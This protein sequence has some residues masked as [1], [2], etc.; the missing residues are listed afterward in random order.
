MLFKCK[1]AKIKAL[2]IKE[3]KM[4]A[5]N[6]RPISLLP[7]ISKVI[8]KLIHDQT[9]DYL[10]RNELL[11]IYQSG[12]RVNHSADKCLPR[13]TDMILN[14]SKNGKHTHITLL[15]LQKAFD[16]SDHKFSTNEVH[17]FFR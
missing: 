1:I 14:G 16:T 7:L 4:E 8:E 6:Y 11:H 2:C 17:W 12:C 5:K 9:Q 10:Q 13:L 3:I 15:D